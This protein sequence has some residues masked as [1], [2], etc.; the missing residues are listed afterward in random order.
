M[1]LLSFLLCA[2][3]ITG[4]TFTER[5][6]D[7]K[8]EKKEGKGGTTVR[9]KMGFLDKRK[10]N[11]DMELKEMKKKKKKSVD[12]SLLHPEIE[13]AREG[14]RKSKGKTKKKK[15]KKEDEKRLKLRKRK[16]EK[17]LVDEREELE[18]EREERPMLVIAV[19]LSVCFFPLSFF[20]SLQPPQKS[21]SFFTH[22]DH[23]FFFF[24]CFFLSLVLSFYPS[25]SFL[26]LSAFNPGKW[27]LV[28]L[29]SYY[30]VILATKRRRTRR[31]EKKGDDVKVVHLVLFISSTAGVKGRNSFSYFRTTFSFESSYSFSCFHVFLPCS[32]F[33]T[34]RFFFLFVLLFL[35]PLMVEKGFSVFLKTLSFSPSSSSSPLINSHQRVFHLL[36]FLLPSKGPV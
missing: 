16:K 36:H 4:K 20:S 8:A 9:P 10:T 3:A 14:H 5:K 6:K 23:F 28:F 31:K 34:S 7:R 25:F 35:S 19:L 18:R 13:D 12:P 2:Q 29:L 1:P 11:G 17:D 33:S 21:W 27:I 30:T 24:S 26:L 22:Q 15:D 32:F